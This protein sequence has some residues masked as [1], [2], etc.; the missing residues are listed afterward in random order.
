[1]LHSLARNRAL[2]E[3]NTRLARAAT[4]VFCLLNGRDLV[5]TADDAE[6]VVVTAAAGELDVPK[7]AAVVQGAI[8]PATG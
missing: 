2:V 7:L 8:G 6:T 5:F 1:L 4:R 3:G